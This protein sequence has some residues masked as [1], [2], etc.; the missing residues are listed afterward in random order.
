M[1]HGKEISERGELLE[2]SVAHIFA[3]RLE[4]DVFKKRAIAI[5]FDNHAVKAGVSAKGTRDIVWV[6]IE[7]DAAEV[8]QI[9]EL[10]FHVTQPSVRVDIRNAAEEFSDN[11]RSAAP[12][13]VKANMVGGPQPINPEIRVIYGAQRRE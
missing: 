3:D 9:I 6:G 5:F 2:K 10:V 12:L 7:A 13:F 4:N 11:P 8:V 1:Q